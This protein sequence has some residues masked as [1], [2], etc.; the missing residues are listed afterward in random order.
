MSI[1]HTL[2]EKLPGLR[3]EPGHR[4][5]NIIVASAYL[6]LML[7]VLTAAMGPAPDDA[8]APTS[9]ESNTDSNGEGHVQE[10]QEAASNVSDQ[11]ANSE[12][13]D[14]PAE[15]TVA[16]E[17]AES[18]AETTDSEVS[19]AEESTPAVMETVLDQQGVEV[20]VRETSDGNLRADYYST[21]TT[22][23]ELAQ[24]L[25]AIA[26]AYAAAV[27]NG[28]DSEHLSIEVRTP[29]GQPVGM[30]TARASDAQAYMDGEI[31]AEV[32][33]LRVLESGEVY[34]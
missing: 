17:P 11:P 28:H 8:T 23:E 18:S 34:E 9:E 12:G 5:R 30:Y 20:E 31:S 7:T 10:Q 22:E 15:T 16:Q 26:G 13:D 2:K 1:I 32:Y 29:D 19:S 4:V 6:F 33:A 27:D 3:T 14:E 25:G 21:A 24:D